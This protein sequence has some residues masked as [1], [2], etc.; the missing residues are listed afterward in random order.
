MCYTDNDPPLVCPF[1][2]EKNKLDNCWGH[3]IISYYLIDIHMAGR[4]RF[5]KLVQKI[6]LITSM[7]M[8]SFMLLYVITGIITINHDLFS[9]PEVKVNH[10]KILVEKPM[11]G[12]PKDY[13]R[14]LKKTLDLKGRTE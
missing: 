4:I 8:L 1:L 3:C 14:Y 6:H 2:Q 11:N 13:A 7:I 9:I 10:S 5:N 12:D